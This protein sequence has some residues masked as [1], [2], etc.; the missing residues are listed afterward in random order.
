MAGKVENTQ[1]G[2]CNVAFNSSD[3]GYTKGYV[4]TEYT[5]ESVEKEVD[6]EDAAVDELITKQ[7]FQVTVPLAERDLARFATLLPGA[8]LVIDGSDSTKTKLV[9]SGGAG[10]SLVAMAKELV[11]APIGG[12]AQDAVT[13]H[14]AVPV[15]NFSFSYEKDN[16]RVYEVVFKALVGERGWVTFGDVTAAAE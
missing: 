15:P 8:T 12:D 7:S 13:I 2:V 11:V 1:M 14:H 3:L 10:T 9:L 6:Q 16:I 4:K 5:V